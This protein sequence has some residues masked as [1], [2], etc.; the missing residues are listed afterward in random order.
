[1]PAIYER[2]NDYANIPAIKPNNL[3]RLYTYN[4]NPMVAPYYYPNQ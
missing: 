2:D 4:T 3:S 1:M